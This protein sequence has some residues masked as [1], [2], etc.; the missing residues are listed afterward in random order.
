MQAKMLLFSMYTRE[1]AAAAGER[2][3]STILHYQP[4]QLN[5]TR[6]EA[7]KQQEKKIFTYKRKTERVLW[8]RRVTHDEMREIEDRKEERSQMSQFCMMKIQTTKN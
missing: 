5:Q 6:K 3:G 1:G 7:Q 4:N 2:R 8:I